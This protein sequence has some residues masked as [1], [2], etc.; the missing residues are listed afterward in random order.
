MTKNSNINHERKP[1]SVKESTVV[2]HTKVK[3]SKEVANAPPAKGPLIYP[4]DHLV[5]PGD[6]TMY[7]AS[8]L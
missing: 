4:K 8:H 1:R 3:S 7:A 6:C 5:E 2:D